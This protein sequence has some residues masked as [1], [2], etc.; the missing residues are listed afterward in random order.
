MLDMNMFPI[1]HA[2]NMISAV[3]LGEFST[4]AELI[5]YCKKECD[6]YLNSG[7]FGRI[8]TFKIGITT[9]PNERFEWYIADEG[10]TGM[11]VLTAMAELSVVEWIERQLIQMYRDEK[12]PRKPGR[13]YFNYIVARQTGKC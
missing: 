5:M 10:Y 11:A 2:M 7:E 8:P 3:K 12:R 1:S 4:R 9:E 6:S 13:S